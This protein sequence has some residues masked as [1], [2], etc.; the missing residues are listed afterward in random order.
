MINR[1]FF[2]SCFILLLGLHSAYASNSG[3]ITV[4]EGK[5]FYQTLGKGEAIIV[6]HG[7]PGLDQSYL[8]PQMERLAKNHQVI[9]YD[10]RGSG[11]LLQTKME[12]AYINLEQFT[13]DLEAVR[14]KF[15]IKK[16]I[17]LGHSWGGMLAMN[18]ATT[19]PEHV[20][21]LILL[22]SAPA[23][24]KGMLAFLNEFNR[25]TLP[26]LAKIKPLMDYALFEK[27]NDKQISDVYRTAFVVYFFNPLNVEK[28][29]LNMNATS[30]QSG[31]K[32]MQ[33]MSQTTTMKPNLNLLS[34]LHSIRAPTLII[35]G[36]EDIIPLWTANEIKEAIPDSKMVVLEACGHFPY[37]EKPEEMF[38]EIEAFLSGE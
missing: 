37:I 38:G 35:H 8:L 28:L 24:F 32:V 11:K 25:R 7:G 31:F 29:S 26:I 12:P 27:L 17:L 21:K 18:Y 30:A 19:Y 4:D 14:A 2:V 15:G 10:Q 5:L 22:N 33:L 34:K 3:Y 36:K 23:D 13:K 9:F 6:L 16:F 1:L 20:S